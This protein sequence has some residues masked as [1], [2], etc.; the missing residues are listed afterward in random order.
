MRYSSRSYNKILNIALNII[1]DIN[2]NPE[3]NILSNMEITQGFSPKFE[4]RGKKGH[5]VASFVTMA[6]KL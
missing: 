2:E 4:E 1:K 6:M 3:D 5:T